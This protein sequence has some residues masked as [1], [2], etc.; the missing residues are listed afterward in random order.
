MS[1]L[2]IVGHWLYHMDSTLDLK[3]EAADY[4]D[5]IATRS[6]LREKRLLAVDLSASV[7]ALQ[8]LAVQDPG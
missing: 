2:L 5:L 7:V 3:S 4:R 8:I 1:L 6:S